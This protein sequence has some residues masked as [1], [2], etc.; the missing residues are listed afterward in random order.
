MTT[1]A[2]YN[3]KAIEKARRN[4]FEKGECQAQSLFSSLDIDEAVKEFK[5]NAKNEY[6]A[7]LI[8]ELKAA[9][10]PWRPAYDIMHEAEKA[11]YQGGISFCKSMVVIIENAQKEMEREYEKLQKEDA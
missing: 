11:Y 6:M 9:G 3:R 10:S 7:L 8:N 1:E 4:S 2:E 5:R